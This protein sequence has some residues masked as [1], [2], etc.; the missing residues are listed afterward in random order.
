MGRSPKVRITHSLL[1]PPPLFFPPTPQEGLRIHPLSRCAFI[2]PFFFSPSIGFFFR[3]K[4][5]PTPPSPL[6]THHS[7]TDHHHTPPQ[8][9][10]VFPENVPPFYSVS[11]FGFLAPP[12]PLPSPSPPAP[13]YVT[14][15]IPQMRKDPPLPPPPPILIFFPN[16]GLVF[17]V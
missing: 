13:L 12:P 7:H 1:S 11:C 16:C 14:M 8:P 4:K 6:N 5:L 3:P 10:R 15:H 2:L 9:T 17:R